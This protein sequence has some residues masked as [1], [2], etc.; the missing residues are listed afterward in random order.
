MTR[1]VTKTRDQSV[2]FRALRPLGLRRTAAERL[3]GPCRQRARAVSQCCLGPGSRI[4]RG[5]ID[6][7]LRDTRNLERIAGDESPGFVKVK[8]ALGA[9]KGPRAGSADSA[10]KAKCL[11]L[12]PV[13][14]HP[15][16]ESGGES[17]SCPG[18]VDGVYIKG[19]RAY[20]FTSKASQGA[21]P[22][23]RYGDN[24]VRIELGE[25]LSLVRRFF[26]AGQNASFVI[27]GEKEVSIWQGRSHLF[28]RGPGSRPRLPRPARSL[29]R[30]SSLGERVERGRLAQEPAGPCNRP[31]REHARRRAPKG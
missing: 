29:T 23:Q 9:T 11:V 31:R 6:D 18:L 30:A 5:Q 3:K 12:G 22:A 24:A 28:Q 1:P 26:F 27:I 21:A 2:T 15:C 8:D 10:C 17:V 20:E 4:R 13:F 14:Q 19:L 25:H 7:V 16:D